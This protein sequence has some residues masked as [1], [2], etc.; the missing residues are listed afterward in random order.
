MT[1]QG[2]AQ[3]I[4]L[5]GMNNIMS[6]RVFL[7]R[8]GLQKHYV[9]QGFTGAENSNSDPGRWREAYNSFLHTREES[10]FKPHCRERKQKDYERVD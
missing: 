2:I 4:L 5:A 6:K 9:M 3:H 8:I 1:S 10:L 7:Q